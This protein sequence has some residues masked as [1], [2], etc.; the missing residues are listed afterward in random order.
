MQFLTALVAIAS[1][2]GLAV[3]TPSLTDIESQ[4]ES[5][6]QGLLKAGCDIVCES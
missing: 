6:V 5:H 1:L 2:A 3:A 4:A